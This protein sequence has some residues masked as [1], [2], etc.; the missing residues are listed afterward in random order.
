[1]EI[2]ETIGKYKILDHIDSGGMGSVYLAN[3]DGVDYA[4]KT[5]DN[6]DPEYIRRF[7][8]EVRLM[9]STIDQ[10]VIEVLDENLDIDDPYFV[11]PLCAC[12]LS[13]A[14]KKGLSDDEKFE[15]AKQFCSGIKALH[16]S[17]I[18]HRDIKPNNALILDGR[19][20]VSDLGLGKF[21]K[22]ETTV[23]TPTFAV[24][25]TLDY[26]PPEIYR[27]GNG[28]N[29]DK[30]CDIFS[31]GRLLY[32]VFSD[33]ENPFAIDASIVKADVYSIINKCTKM[34]PNSRYQDV[35]EVIDALN[36]CQKTRTSF[37]SIHEITSAHIPGT[38]DAE[39]ADQVYNYLLSNQNDLGTL[40]VD[41]KVLGSDRFQLMLMHK[42]GAVS[43]FFQLL[44]STYEN[45]NGYRIQFED[46]DVLVS[47]ARVLMQ[48]TTILQEKQDLLEFAIHISV[49]Y[50]RWS[51]MQVVISMFNALTEEEI[52]SIAPFFSANK[53]DLNYIKD[54][55][56]N[57]LPESVKVFIR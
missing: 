22:R 4:L 12:S 54:S 26:M 55:V 8:R 49:E 53:G 47:R 21:E 42:R 28:R 23:L 27:D 33:G 11:M 48:T 17:G 39:F 2:G 1:M 30:R 40:I 57:P 19:I 20:K 41:L 36:I 5:C 16:D 52:R 15:Y 35:S 9:K 43:S 7:K 51:S 29:A 34:Q 38:N 14:V 18:I 50:N 13:T 3:K 32:Y 24:M 46:V 44:L 37:M 6:K 45:N 31:I 56:R 25:G 10:N